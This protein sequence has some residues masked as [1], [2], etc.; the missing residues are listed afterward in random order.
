MGGSQWGKG[1]RKHER[2]GEQVTSQRLWRKEVKS[3]LFRGRETHNQRLEG[4]MTKA[5]GYFERMT[6][7]IQKLKMDLREAGG[8]V[9]SGIY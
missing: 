5:G 1:N 7:E 2:N 8:L 9:I 3:S 4:R 6:K